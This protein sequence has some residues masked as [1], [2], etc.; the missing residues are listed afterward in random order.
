MAKHAAVR[1]GGDQMTQLA[2]EW[3]AGWIAEVS[4]TSV[5]NQ[6]VVWNNL[7]QRCSYDFQIEGS[8]PT[9]GPIFWG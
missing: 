2:L 5:V 9:F 3:R 7:S 4:G 1:V 6:C 8:K